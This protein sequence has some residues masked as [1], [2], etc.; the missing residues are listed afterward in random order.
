MAIFDTVNPP[1]LGPPRGFAHGLLAPAGGRVLF[2]AGQTAAEAGA[3]LA[4][5]AYRHQ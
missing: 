3:D 5:R 4:A 1:A 2:V